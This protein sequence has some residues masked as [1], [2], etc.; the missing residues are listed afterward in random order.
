MSTSGGPLSPSNP[1]V[2]R[3]RRLAGRRSARSDEG[4][5]VVEGATLIAEALGAGAVVESVFATPEFVAGPLQRRIAAESALYVV[6]SDTLR[7]AVATTNPQPVA[8]IV[9]AI[10]TPF[11]A[12]VG[13]RPTFVVVAAGINDPGNAGTIIRSAAAAGADAVVL[14]TGSVDLYNPKCVRATAGALFHV[15]ISTEVE[16]TSIATLGLSTFGA[17]VDA[18]STCYEVD[19]SGPLALV[20][21]HERHGIPSDLALTTAVTIPMH[22]PT[23]SLNAAMAATVLC[24]EVARQRRVV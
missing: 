20:I 15:A 19:L 21:G 12:V 8:A 5:F 11:D 22:G 13:S 3:L 14:T 1:K 6:E 4:A 10:D 17:T 18:P 23:E 2:Q 24:F 16:P 9:Q 7:R